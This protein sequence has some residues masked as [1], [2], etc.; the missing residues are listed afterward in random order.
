MLGLLLDTYGDQKAQRQ[1]SFKMTYKIPHETKQEKPFKEL[2]EIPKT[3]KRIKETREYFRMIDKEIEETSSFR[4]MFL[5]LIT[6]GM[7]GLR[8]VKLL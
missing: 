5:N 8:R 3:I 7:H 4:F 2:N 6:L 1:G